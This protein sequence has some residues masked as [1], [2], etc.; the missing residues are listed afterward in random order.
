MRR[1]L[2]TTLVEMVLCVPLLLACTDGYPTDDVVSLPESEMN[3]AQLLRA[4]NRIGAG[5]IPGE[6]WRYD[7]NKGC[8]LRVTSM[9]PL[10]AVG[11]DTVALT[12]LTTRRAST[13]RASSIGCG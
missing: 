6:T 9:N 5:A 11:V 7:L 13:G 2:I 12:G 3:S 1:S 8:M 10:G 4:M